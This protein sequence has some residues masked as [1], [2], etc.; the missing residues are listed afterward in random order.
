MGLTKLQ[1]MQ[2][3]GR[4]FCRFTRPLSMD[5]IAMPS[6]AG[7]PNVIPFDLSVDF[8]LFLAWGYT[9]RGTLL[10]LQASVGGFVDL[11]SYNN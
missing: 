5:V 11:W 10:Q 2:Q 7:P 8:F 6:K 3:D 9:Y 1:T 4:V